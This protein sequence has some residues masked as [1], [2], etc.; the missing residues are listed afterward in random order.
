MRLQLA[1]VC[2][3]AEQTPHGKLDLRGVFNDLAAPGFPAKHDMVLVLAVEWA[4]SDEGTYAFQ[5]DL[6]D[7]SDRTTMTIRGHSNVDRREPG[8]SP[9]RTCV[10]LPLTDVIF[11]QPGRYTF[12]ISVKGRTHEGPSLYLVEAESM[13]DASN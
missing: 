4:R 5:V 13:G 3:H 7:S 12:R 10:I 1:L 8:R 9:A 2:D 11:P 6:V